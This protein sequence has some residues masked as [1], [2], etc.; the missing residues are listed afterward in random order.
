MVPRPDSV[1]AEILGGSCRIPDGCPPCGEWIEEHVDPEHRI[2][3][4]GMG[5][6]N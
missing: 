1:E 2:I 3:V 6:K 4:A 5:T